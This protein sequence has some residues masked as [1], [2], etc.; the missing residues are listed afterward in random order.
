MERLDKPVPACRRVPEL[1]PVRRLVVDATFPKES[2]R[3]VIVA[4]LALV[5][6]DGGFQGRFSLPVSNPTRLRCASCRGEAHSVKL[7]STGGDRL[8]A[9]VFE[10]TVG[11]EVCDDLVGASDHPVGGGGHLVEVAT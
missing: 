10:L 5:E 2:P 7:S 1:P 9:V 8:G 3:P 4:Y 11:V 6:V